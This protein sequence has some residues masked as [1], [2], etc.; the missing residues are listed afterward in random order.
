MKASRLRRQDCPLPSTLEAEAGGS[1]QIQVW[2]ILE[3]PGQ[4]GISGKTLISK[5]SKTKTKQNKLSKRNKNY[6]N[7]KK[8]NYLYLQV[9][10]FYT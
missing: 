9:I 5:K 10:R 6:I 8:V 2:S 7:S 1:L 4:L 3:I